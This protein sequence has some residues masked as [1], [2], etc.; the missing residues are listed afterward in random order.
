MLA[1]IVAVAHHR[2]IGK[3][4]SLIWHL[5]NDLKF[6]KEKTTGHVIIMGRKTF[7][8]LPF[9]LPNREHW[10]ITTNKGF[11]APEGVRVFSS[12]EAVVEAAKNLDVAYVIGGAQI[13]EAFLPYVDVMHITEVDHVFEGDAHFP[14]FD[15]SAFTITS[16]V[17]GTV[18][19]KNKYPHR[20]VTYERKGH[21]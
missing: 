20:F 15:A 12:P 11:N 8:S 4:N 6:F 3:D 19:D 10:V 13:Y 1:L 2:V 16:V 18:D 17:A 5:P 21:N 7:E 14:E 9:L